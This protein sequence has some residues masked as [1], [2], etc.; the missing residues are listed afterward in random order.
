MI[1][2]P[3]GSEDIE[4]LKVTLSRSNPVVCQTEEREKERDCFLPRLCV[5]LILQLPTG[6]KLVEST[7][8][9]HHFNPKKSV[10]TLN[11]RGKLIGFAKRHQCKGI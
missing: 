10:M 6:E 8:F 11:Q 2:K 7:L 3:R 4:F 1:L 5:A 9:P